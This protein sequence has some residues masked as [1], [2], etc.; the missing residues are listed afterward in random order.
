MKKITIKPFKKTEV[1]QEYDPTEDLGI[2][3]ERIKLL[4]ADFDANKEFSYEDLY[5]KTFVLVLKLGGGLLYDTV[6]DILTI[7][8]S[9]KAAAFL[10]DPMSP[11]SLITLNNM[12]RSFRPA[13]LAVGDFM[14][15]YNRVYVVPKSLPPTFEVG[16]TCFCV[17]FMS[18]TK[19]QIEEVL[20]KL[21][22]ESLPYRILHSRAICSSLL[23][24]LMDLR[25]HAPP[26]HQDLFAF[27]ALEGQAD[28]QDDEYDEPLDLIEICCRKILNGVHKRSLAELPEDLVR[29]LEQ[30]H[31]CPSCG[32][33]FTQGIIGQA[34]CNLMYVCSVKCVHQQ[35][36]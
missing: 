6:K 19:T 27:P 13:L 4:L 36:S 9:T 11:S 15:Y 10:L 1:G 24:E 34:K 21:W 8:C 17:E 28:G 14:I 16:M 29:R 7:H 5:R 3:T 26:E 2:I 30:H 32:M 25:K 20:V 12:C 31:K 18:K 23:S 22:N 35:S 33:T